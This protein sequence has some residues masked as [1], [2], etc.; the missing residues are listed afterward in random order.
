V[1]G[2]TV[3]ATSELSTDSIL[4]LLM[5][6][7]LKR[8]GEMPSSGSKLVVSCRTRKVDKTNVSLLLKRFGL[9]IYIIYEP[10]V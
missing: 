3:A 7:H 8:L 10:I 2:V 9:I 1:T 6:R 4:L 5:G